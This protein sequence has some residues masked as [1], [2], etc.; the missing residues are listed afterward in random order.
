[1]TPDFDAL[2]RKESR[3]VPAEPEAGREGIEDDRLRLVFT[4]CPP[5]SRRIRRWRSRCARYAG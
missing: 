4:C 2:Y 1:V 3:R 5:R